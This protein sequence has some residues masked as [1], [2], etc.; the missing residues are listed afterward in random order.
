MKNNTISKKMWSIVTLSSL[1][2]TLIICSTFFILNKTQNRLSNALNSRT[3]T[4]NLMRAM[5]IDSYQINSSLKGLFLLEKDTEEYTE[6]I[7][8]LNYNMEQIDE[9]LV[10]LKASYQN[11]PTNEAE[12]LK[13]FEANYSELKS[14][15]FEI[16]GLLN[17]SKKDISQAIKL[18]NTDFSVLFLKTEDAI[19]AV[20]DTYV[21]NGHALSKQQESDNLIVI[22]GLLTLLAI[23]LFIV[24]SQA[25]IVTKNISKNSQ[26]LMSFLEK[27]KNTSDLGERIDIQSNDELKFISISVN[28]LLDKINKLVSSIVLTSDKL[29][30][31]SSTLTESTSISLQAS[32]NTI[33]TM[34]SLMNNSTS[35]FNSIAKGKEN[36]TNLSTNIVNMIDSTSNI[37][38]LAEN[39]NKL[40]SKGIETVKILTDTSLQ[41]INSVKKIDELI[42]I[43]V[44]SSKELDAL[45]YKINSISEQTNLLSLNASIEA[46]RAG[47][48]G[49][50]FAIV[51]S[52]IGNL[53]FES[54]TLS[55]ESKL[56]IDNMISKVSSTVSSI[57]LLKKN[58]IS[59]DNTVKE[60]EDIFTEILS[61]V[62]S[63]KKEITELNL[64][65]S[66]IENEKTSVINK[67]TE[68]YTLIEKNK[69]L[70]NSVYEL[71]SNGM[72]SSKEIKKE[73]DLLSGICINLNKTVNEF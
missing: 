22:I 55:N 1:T 17:G 50:G 6:Q 21:E 56:Q 11:I 25:Y 59:L 9:R 39:T 4:L 68:L 63:V 35:E 10:T 14:L 49:A 41:S 67:M 7:S 37:N 48:H 40:T 65:N 38:I 64:N 52:E 15:T 47:S 28:E 46:A 8:F 51:A 5:G 45:T 44:D 26:S 73:T 29:S 57:E 60:N 31:A 58:F 27:I 16:T 72:S 33:D 12:P 20:A 53:A 13:T 70:I 42:N 62:D 43:I 24:F 54:S 23:A 32:E 71:C 30:N 2:F 19:D 3:D 18:V 61:S 69:L 66:K 34:N 36:L